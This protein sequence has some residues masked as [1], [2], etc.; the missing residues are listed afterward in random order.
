MF[1]KMFTS[2]QGRLQKNLLETLFYQTL[3]GIMVRPKAES[4][5]RVHL[6]KKSKQ[7]SGYTPTAVVY[8]Y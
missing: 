3:T 6:L 4:E 7:R 5:A 1:D 2:S 8:N